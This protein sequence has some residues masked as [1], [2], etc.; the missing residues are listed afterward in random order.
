MFKKLGALCGPDMRISGAVF[1]VWS[2]G[3]NEQYQLEMS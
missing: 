1:I 2:T 3:M